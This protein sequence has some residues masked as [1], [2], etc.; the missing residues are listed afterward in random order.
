MHLFFK[1]RK[2]N[3]L[4]LLHSAHFLLNSNK[5]REEVWGYVQNHVNGPK[6]D[7]PVVLASAHVGTYSTKKQRNKK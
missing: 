5:P 3:L 2:H 6:E 7:Y 1:Q 4:L